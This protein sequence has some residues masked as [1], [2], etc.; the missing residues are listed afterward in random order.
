MRTVFFLSVL[1]LS[2]LFSA[3]SDS[4]S[5]NQT[6]TIQDPTEQMTTMR[7]FAPDSNLV[8][9]DL[10]KDSAFAVAQ[11]RWVAELY[12]ESVAEEARSFILEPLT[13]SRLLAMA[14]LGARGET[15][16]Q[17]EQILELGPEPVHSLSEPSFPFTASAVTPDHIVWQSAAWG[18]EDY[19]FRSAFLNDLH[20]LAQPQLAEIPFSVIGSGY[21]DIV[22]EWVSETSSDQSSFYVL[23][24]EQPEA[25]RLVLADSFDLQLGFSDSVDT[26]TFTGLFDTLGEQQYWVPM[27]KISG[28]LPYYSD[29]SYQAVE[30]PLSSGAFSLLVI[31]P[32]VDY[33]SDVEEGLQDGLPE[34]L[35][36]LQP[37][38]VAFNIPEVSISFGTHLNT[39]LQNRG[40][41]S[42]F[43]EELADFSGVNGL[44]YLFMDDVRSRVEFSLTPYGI[45]G[46]G[47][48][49][50]SLSATADE[51]DFLWA[52][53]IVVDVSD[54][55][56]D[57]SYYVP[58]GEAEAR[59]FMFALYDK[60]SELILFMGR[61]LFAGGGEAGEWVSGFAPFVNEWDLG[62]DPPVN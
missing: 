37:Q 4:D 55:V 61:V 48:S 52:G 33:Y 28:T 51:P 43:K 42:A 17:L 12:L 40:M 7:S 26:E 22:E 6:T 1:A 31:M 16:T 39:L 24:P 8:T 54:W 58:A 20:I 59:P 15:A 30:L 9:P 47:L 19:L 11:N 50:T 29:E 13:V 36:A 60:E 27:I 41:Y 2:V 32:E 23:S 21:T 46:R 56:D 53:Y 25:V 34:I 38:P 3:C 14:L 57:G 44:G 49:Y 35:A 45:Q 62:I 10:A 18:H 5:T